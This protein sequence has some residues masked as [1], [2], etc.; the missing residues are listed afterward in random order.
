[1]IFDGNQKIFQIYQTCNWYK[2]VM[3]R[4]I[5][6]HVFYTANEIPGLARHPIA[7][8]PSQNTFSLHAVFSVMYANMWAG[9]EGIVPII[10]GHYYECYL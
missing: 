10:S 5:A 8:K 4:C 6:K 2:W 9:M 1:M 3:F 7:R